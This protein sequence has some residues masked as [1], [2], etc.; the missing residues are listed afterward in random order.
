MTIHAT[1]VD[2]DTSSGNRVTASWLNDVNIAVYTALGTGG[3][4]PTTATQVVNNLSTAIAAKTF[5]SLTATNIYTTSDVTLKYDVCPFV[6]GLRDVLDITPITYK[7]KTDPTKTTFA[8]FSAQ[9]VAGS[10][11]EAL[12]VTDTGALTLQDRPIVAALVNAVKQLH[13]EITMLKH[14]QERS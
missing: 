8:G 14:K 2:N 12:G 1:F 9:D 4:A 10:I 11:P 6:R 7:F 3:T 5:T 13:K